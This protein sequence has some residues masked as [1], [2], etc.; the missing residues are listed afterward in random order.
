[1][2]AGVGGRG[3][4][5]C[6]FGRSAAILDFSLGTKLN[7][8]ASSFYFIKK[9]IAKELIFQDNS[10]SPFTPPPNVFCQKAIPKIH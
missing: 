4:K 7:F 6:F 3:R 10:F 1:M 8:S 5:F 9:K 2:K